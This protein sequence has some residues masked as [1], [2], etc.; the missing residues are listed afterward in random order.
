[1]SLAEVAESRKNQLTLDAFART[2]LELPLGGHNFSVSS[3]DLDTREQASLVVSL[4]NISAVNLA[5]TNSTVVWTLGTWETIYGPAIGS[6]GHVKKSVLLL[7]TEPWFMLLVG[8]HE[9]GS[10]VAVVE[11]VWRSIG[12][13][14]LTDNQNVWA[15]TEWIGEDSNRSEVNIG[16]VA[17][18][19][20]SR[21]SV[22]VPLWQ[23]INGEFTAFG[24][25]GEGL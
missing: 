9:L 2:N 1:M 18:S 7:K 8:L 5:G 11:L 15:L 10:L 4:Y 13:P 22:E 12:I 23:V 20:A 3:G 19:L 6:I 25:L 24:D 16:V 17:W 21:A 14:A